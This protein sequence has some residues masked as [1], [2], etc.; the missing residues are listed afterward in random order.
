LAQALRAVSNELGVV[1]RTWRCV[2]GIQAPFGIDGFETN[3][4]IENK[5]SGTI[6]SCLSNTR[7]FEI[8][9]GVQEIYRTSSGAPQL[10]L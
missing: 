4:F 7:P 10:A 1:P 3:A 2:S 9:A 8:A 5:A 6:F